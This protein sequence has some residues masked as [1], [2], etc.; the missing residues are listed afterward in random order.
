[1]DAKQ[2]IPTDPVQLVRQ[3]DAEAIRNRLED[4]DREREALLVLLRA[5]Q[6]A[7]RSDRKS[8]AEAR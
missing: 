8:S 7:Q 3:L 1:M 5:A 4:L 2:T 6:R